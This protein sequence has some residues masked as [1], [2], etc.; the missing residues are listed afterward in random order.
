MD[1]VSLNMDNKLFTN[2]VIEIHTKVRLNLFIHPLLAERI[3]VQIYLMIAVLMI[4]NLEDVQS[5]ALQMFQKNW[6]L[7]LLVCVL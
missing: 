7:R 3:F 1:I 4:G 2:A 6:M 5:P